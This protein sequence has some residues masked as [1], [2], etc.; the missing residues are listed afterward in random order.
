MSDWPLFALFIFTGCSWIAFAF[1]TGKL[2]ADFLNRYPR[3][4]EELIPSAFD[5]RTKHPEKIIFFFRRESLPLL[6]SD[7]HLW[8]LRQ[9]VKFLLWLSILTPALAMVVCAFL[10]LASQ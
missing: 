1:R 7:P 6:K 10:A 2:Y 4:A 3:E 8:R 9:Q 5:P